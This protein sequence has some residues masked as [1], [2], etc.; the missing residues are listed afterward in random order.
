[1]TTATGC[2]IAVMR[3]RLFYITVPSLHTMQAIASDSKCLHFDRF[4][5]HRRTKKKGYGGI[6]ED[7]ERSLIV[8]ALG[9]GCG[10]CAASACFICAEASRL[11]VYMRAVPPDD[12]SF[13]SKC[14]TSSAGR[15]PVLNRNARLPPQDDGQFYIEMRDFLHRITAS[16]LSK[17]ATSSRG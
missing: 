7:C 10:V 16:Y 6:K 2:V 3:W 1:M 4:V 5:A 9:G 8:M 13:R 11:V 14:A 17:C 15:R 12:A